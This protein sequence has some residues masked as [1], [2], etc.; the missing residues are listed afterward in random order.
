MKTYYLLVPFSIGIA[1]TAQ[2]TINSQLRGAV[3]S[4]LVATLISFLVGTLALGVMIVILNE[5]IPS[6]QQLAGVAWYK[7]TGGLLGAFIV[8]AI[9]VSIKNINPSAL[10][11][12]V[13]AGQLVT[14]VIIEHFGFMGIP[15][16]A[17]NWTKLT[18][19]ALLVISVYLIN[20]KK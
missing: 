9:I 15:R 18:G 16:I 4:A 8:M 10:F 6:A 17:V 5:K 20:Q 1:L 7:Y 11:A 2:A 3:N 13:V 14:A 19:I 12:L